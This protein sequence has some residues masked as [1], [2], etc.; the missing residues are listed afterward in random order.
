MF[1][2]TSEGWGKRKAEQNRSDKRDLVRRG[3]AHGVLVYCSEEPVG[4]C[5]F[6]P[7]DELPRIDRK[8]EYTPAKDDAWRIT[9]FF[10]DR[11][12]RRLGVTR[13]A[14]AASLNT[15][16]EMG[17]KSVEAYPVLV[18]TKKTSASYL[19]SGTSS[20]FEAAGFV[21]VRR[22]GKGSALYRRDLSTWKER[23]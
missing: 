22:L 3:K 17:A 6:G 2:H 4:W 19:W 9:C 12:H 7:A 5:Q 10:V 1:Y 21:Q 13:R 15:I 23:P 20:L 16:R 11:D 14:L 18:G 8:R